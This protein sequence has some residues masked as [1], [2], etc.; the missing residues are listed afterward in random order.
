MLWSLLWA[1]LR[2]RLR[3]RTRLRPLLWLRL[4]S[5]L[6][7]VRR[8]LILRWLLIIRRPIL[9]WLLIVRRPLIL[10]WPL[11]VWRLLVIRRPILRRLLVI[12]WPLVLRRSLIVR[13]LS[14]VRRLSRSVAIV[15]RRITRP[16]PIIRRRLSWPI[17]IVRRTIRRRRVHRPV[18]GPRFDVDRRTRRRRPIVGWPIAPVAAI[19][20]PGVP[21]D[22]TR[23]IPG[24]RWTI[25]SMPS[26]PRGAV[27]IDAASPVPSPSAPSPRLVACNQRPNADAHAKRDK[28]CRDDRSRARRCIDNRRIVL[29]HINDL[30][31]CGLDYVH[32]LRS[33]LHDDCLLLIRPQRTRRIRLRAQPLNRIRHRRLVRRHGRPNRGIVVD[34]LRHH[35]Q[36]I[37]EVHQRDEGRVVALLLR[38]IRQLAV[39]QSGI[40]C[41]PV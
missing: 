16:V 36:N 26:S 35:L 24:V 10:R 1:R 33:L 6:L 18:S 5:R 20:R 3:S 32:R 29:R 15:R 12:R 9:W 19:P 7:I 40:V 14:G 27:V 38:S 23:T 25:P 34:V 8:S 41:K 11:I 21:H 2:L 39:R 17:S 30:R 31:I 13:W 37:R 22:R 4:W 28:R